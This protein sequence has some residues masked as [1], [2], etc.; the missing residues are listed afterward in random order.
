[1]SPGLLT[2]AIG[3]ALVDREFVLAICSCCFGMAT[4]DAVSFV[5]VC[6]V[7]DDT[8]EG[9]GVDDNVGGGFTVF[10]IPHICDSVVLTT[11]RLGLLGLHI[12]ALSSGDIVAVV[13][14]LP[15]PDVDGGGDVDGEGKDDS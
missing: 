13:L 7:D 11:L 10:G 6:C 8:A 4:F 3:A 15:A 1:L 2:G 14:L 5:V 12:F 9:C